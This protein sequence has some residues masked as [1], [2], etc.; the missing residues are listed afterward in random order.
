MGFLGDLIM[1]KTENQTV[2]NT[3]YLALF[4]AITDY[5]K[6]RYINTEQF[7]HILYYG[8]V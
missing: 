3:I 7:N 2:A 8:V 5:C 1:N 6:R 4:D